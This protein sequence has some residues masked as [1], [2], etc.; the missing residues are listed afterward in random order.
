MSLLKWEIVVCLNDPKTQKSC[1]LVYNGW[2]PFVP[3]P[4]LVVSFGHIDIKLPEL[5]EDFVVWHQNEEQPYFDIYTKINCGRY[6]FE[7]KVKEFN[8]AG[9]FIEP[10]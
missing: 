2:F 4:N 5:C 3:I 9:F 10:A 8:D 6:N 7:T 1:D